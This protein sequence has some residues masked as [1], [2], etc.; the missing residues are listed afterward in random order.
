MGF[1]KSDVA[2]YVS[3]NERVLVAKSV[4]GAKTLKAIKF[5]PGVKGSAQV[6]TLTD[7]VTVQAGSCG[8]NAAGTTTLSK[9]NIV[10]GQF[11]VN[12]ALCE[13]DL[14]G[15]FAEW[16]LNVAVGKEVLPFEE[17]IA[18][19]KVKGIAKAV[20][21]LIWN[22]DTTGSTS[23]YLDVTDGL[24]K[25]IGE[26]AGVVDATPT[27]S[28]TLLANSIDAINLMIAN[29]PADIIDAEDL[30]LFT[31]YDVVMKYIAAYN[32][33]NQF[34]GTLLLDG[35]TMAVTIPNTMIKLQGVGGLNGKNKAYLTP[36]S[37]F[38]A[39]GDVQGDEAQFKLWYSDDNQEFRFV[40][41]F[42]IGVQVAFPSFVVE[43]TK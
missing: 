38:V 26:A 24:V 28:T 21:L 33:S 4:L 15:T 11:K 42:N 8:W 35:S 30:T 23:T 27:G 41:K 36:A 7:G 29:I 37:N 32:A 16:E 17:V 18:D 40:S 31:G 20:E 43:Y 2:G 14:V 22:G 25:I 3:A 1:S 13:R 9:R 39:G 34:A 5:Q 12:E 19:A 6:N 10:T